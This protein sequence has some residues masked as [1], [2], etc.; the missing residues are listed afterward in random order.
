MNP[1]VLIPARMAATRLPGKPLADIAGLPMIIRVWQQ[2]VTAN[3][4]PVVVA[5]GDPEIVAAVE[6]RG[7]RAVLTDPSLPSGSDRVHAAAQILDP[8]GA[9]DI[10]LNVQGDVPDISP[11]DL[12]A[13]LQPLL[14]PEVDVATPVCPLPAGPRVHEASVV[15]AVLAPSPLADTYR[16]P[17]FSR[18]PVPHGE[19]PFYEH[20]GVYAYRRAALERFVTLPPSPLELRERLEQLRILAD[21]AVFGAVIVPSS[22]ISVDTPDDLAEARRRLGA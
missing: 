21:G 16:V 6:A 14:D 22:P 7:G 20:I 11:D 12:R 1:L 3:I 10:L 13:V 18:N 9:H 8:D 15:K 19:G 17:Y 4:G 5:A 2:A